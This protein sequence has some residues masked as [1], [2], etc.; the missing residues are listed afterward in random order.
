MMKK[1]FAFV[2]ILFGLLFGPT[3][4]AYEMSIE[5]KIY[6]GGQPIGIKLNSGVEVVGTYA[7]YEGSTIHKPWDEAGIID[8]DKIV[9][10]NGFSINS[11]AELAD[12]LAKTYGKEVSIKLLRG[13]SEIYSTI[14]PIKKNNTLSLGLYVKDSVMGVG[15]LTY[16]I[17]EAKIYGSLGHKI[18]VDYFNSGRI[19][20]ATV[21]EVI[22]PSNG[23][24]GEKK[25]TITGGVIGTV[26]L[27]EATGV[28]GYVT[29]RFD[30]SDMK[31]LNIKTREEINLG[32]AEIW[33]CIDGTK[34]ECF[35]IEITKLVKQKNKD[36]KGIHFKVT[37]KELLAKTGGII[38]GM[39][40]SP[41]I[42]NNKLIGA[43]TH[44]SLN[45]PTYGY[46]IYIEWMLEDMGVTIVE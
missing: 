11:I 10:L 5:D 32:K 31:L 38:Q 24:A 39:S 41:I 16:Y 26:E 7:I 43:V 3:V 27:N 33:T 8:G 14:T 20:E 25:A 12:A 30:T 36:I 18:A 22:K 21:D 6:V 23:I 44:V 4:K 2:L 19:Y 28:Q 29:A 17:D 13:S 45:D 46:G 15:T 40:G 1:I 42:Q 37:D 35:E 34:V 9:E